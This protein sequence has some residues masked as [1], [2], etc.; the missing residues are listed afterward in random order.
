MMI[1]IYRLY[2]LNCIFWVEWSNWRKDLREMTNFDLYY[3]WSDWDEIGEM[4]DLVD[5]IGNSLVYENEK[6]C[7][8][9]FYYAL[10]KCEGLTS[11]KGVSLFTSPEFEELSQASHLLSIAMR[12]NGNGP[13]EYAPKTE[14]TVRQPGEVFAAK[15]HL[16]DEPIAKPPIGGNFHVQ[17]DLPPSSRL[18]NIHAMVVKESD[19]SQEPKSKSKVSGS[20]SLPGRF[21]LYRCSL[22]ASQVKESAERRIFSTV[23]LLEISLLTVELLKIQN[24]LQFGD[25]ETILFPDEIPFFYQFEFALS[26]IQ[27]SISDAGNEVFATAEIDNLR[28]TSSLLMDVI[29]GHGFA[30]DLAAVKLAEELNLTFDAGVRKYPIL[31][32]NLGV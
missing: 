11:E 15:H 3:L 29:S 8:W 4:F 5:G 22:L 12:A 25:A 28:R 20:G 26:S 24:K 16:L 1:N 10:E 31:A 6:A 30:P 17:S 27:H 21:N 19:L 18:A 9:R 7:F 13:I 2:V 14:M 32:K 23:D